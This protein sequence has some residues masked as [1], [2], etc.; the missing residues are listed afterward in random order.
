MS[1]GTDYSQIK[2]YVNDTEVA[3]LN[4]S[5]ESNYF[6][7][8]IDEGSILRHCRNIPHRI[9]R[10]CIYHLRHPLTCIHL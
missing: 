1:R 9:A 6:M 2:G 4:A 5:M 7:F 10:R 3:S 8:Y